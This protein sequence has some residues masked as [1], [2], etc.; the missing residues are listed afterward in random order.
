MK[1]P[2]H[3]T[4]RRNAA[5]KTQDRQ[6][7]QRLLPIPRR[8][9]A[10]E[11]RKSAHGQLPRR[12]PFLCIDLIPQCFLMPRGRCG[13]PHRWKLTELRCF[14]TQCTAVLLLGVLPV[15]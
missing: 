5:L 9:A 11:A 2:R 15:T 8:H 7:W 6:D 13:A 10:V 1:N 4:T 3:T 12:S 14:S